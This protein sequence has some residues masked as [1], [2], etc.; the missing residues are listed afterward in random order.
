MGNNTKIIDISSKIR[1]LYLIFSL[2]GFGFIMMINVVFNLSGIVVFSLLFI[3]LVFVL[4]GIDYFIT[5]NKIVLNLGN[6]LVSKHKEYFL[7]KGMKNL[8]TLR[9][10]NELD[11]DDEQNK[12]AFTEFLVKNELDKYDKIYL[13]VQILKRILSLF[14]I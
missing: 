3:L 13:Q 2:T 1:K 12:D 9:I 4:Y 14:Q 8:D 5:R 7:S 6:I 11:Y 10:R